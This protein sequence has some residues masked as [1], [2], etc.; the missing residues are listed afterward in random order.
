MGIGYYFFIDS[1][2]ILDGEPWFGGG[3]AQN[4]QKAYYQI[5][6]IKQM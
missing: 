1:W 3:K 5:I 6:I 2:M 4:L